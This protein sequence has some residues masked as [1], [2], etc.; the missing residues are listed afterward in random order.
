MILMNSYPVF[1]TENILLKYK[2]LLFFE[3]K[4]NIK[5]KVKSK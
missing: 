1:S 4:V 5:S 2:V 3:F